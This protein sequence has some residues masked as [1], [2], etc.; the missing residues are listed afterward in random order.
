MPAI[1]CVELELA[2]YAIGI[3]RLVDQTEHQPPRTQQRAFSFTN[4]CVY[5][6]MKSG[7]G[8]VKAIEQ[9]MKSRSIAVY[10]SFYNPPTIPYRGAIP[11]PASLPL[12]REDIPLGC[13]L[14]RAV[15]AHRA[16][17][18]LPVGRTPQFAEMAV[19][20]P[21]ATDDYAPHGW[22]LETFIADEILRCREG[23]LFEKPDDEDLYAL[24]YQRDNP[25]ASMIMISIDLLD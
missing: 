11:R 3:G 23:R 19:L 6:A 14:L 25:I 4:D 17:A 16:L 8:Q 9:Y 13:R 15:D 21:S 24:L 22:R 2:D 20:A 1:A 18:N 10:Y 7:D 5:G 12:R